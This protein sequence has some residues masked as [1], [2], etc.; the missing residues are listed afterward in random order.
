M[1]EWK[2]IYRRIVWII[3]SVTISKTSC[4][5]AWLAINAKVVGDSFSK[6]LVYNGYVLVVVKQSIIFVEGDQYSCNIAFA[7][8]MEL[9]GWYPSRVALIMQRGEVVLSAPV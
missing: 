4:P 3:Q 6:K 9:I 7:F 8:D 1:T 5:N 2:A